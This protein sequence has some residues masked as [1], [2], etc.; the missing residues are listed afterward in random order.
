[1][2][3]K[4]VWIK[5]AQAMILSNLSDVEKFMNLLFKDSMII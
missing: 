4:D 3:A 1:M 2:G 5:N